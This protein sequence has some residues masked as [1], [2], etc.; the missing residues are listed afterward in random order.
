MTMISRSTL[1]VASLFAVSTAGALAQTKP[2][3]DTAGA[4]GLVAKPSY[5]SGSVDARDPALSGKLAKGTTKVPA[6][7]NPHVAGAT[8]R[9]VVPGTHSTIAT[10]SKNTLEQKTGPTG[11]VR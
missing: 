8:G 11:Q 9:T 6:R 10:D 2:G 1:L 5:P 7:H 4:G 3:D